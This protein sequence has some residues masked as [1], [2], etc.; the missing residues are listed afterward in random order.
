MACS[1]MPKW[2]LRPAGFSALKSPAPSNVRRVLHEGAEIRR[3]AEQ[4][5]HVLGEDVQHLARGVPARD[6]LGVGGERRQAAVPA[7][8][9]LA[10]QH[11]VAVLGEFRIL[12]A[13]L[14]ELGPPGRMQRLPARCRCRPGNARAR[15]R[16]RGTWRL[17]ASRN[18]AWSGGSLPRPAVRHAPRWCLACWA[19]RRRCG[20][21]R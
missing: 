20:C 8:R 14:F 9:Q 7:V 12:L 15:R 11:A 2:R 17:P 16:A 18:G 10:A 5:R 13:V 4:P 1:R 19:R 21:R 3:A 6:P